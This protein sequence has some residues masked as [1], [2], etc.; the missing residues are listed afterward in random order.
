MRA[1]AAKYRA[2][3]KPEI[4]L[5]EL[6]EPADVGGDGALQFVAR[7][8]AATGERAYR[9]RGSRLLATVDCTQPTGAG[10]EEDEAGCASTVY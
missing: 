1:R 8:Q 3:N 6:T 9:Y 4:Q 5:A 7:Q 2:Q 10:A